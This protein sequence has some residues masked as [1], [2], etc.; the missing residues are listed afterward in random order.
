[1][2]QMPMGPTKMAPPNVAQMQNQYLPSSQFQGS[3]PMLGTG[4][5]GV[6][7]P[8]PQGGIAQVREE[9]PFSTLCLTT[10]NT[11]VLRVSRATT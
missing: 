7:Q 9:I 4:P 2:F 10:A 1:M 6:A 11:A 8:G 5:V 3:S